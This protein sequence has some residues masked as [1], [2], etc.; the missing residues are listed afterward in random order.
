VGSNVVFGAGEYGPS[1]HA[2]QR[3]LG[4][5]L[6][7]VVQ[8][9]SVPTQLR[10]DIKN[11]AAGNAVAFEFRVGI[12]LRQSFVELA[13]KLALA[14]PI[15]DGDLEDLRT[16][17]LKFHGTVDD[18]ERMFMAGLL[19]SANV[20]SLRRMA[21][22]PGASITFTF[23]TITNARV[24]HII[25]LG[26]ETVPESVAKPAREGADAL[27]HLKVG[28]ALEK[29]AESESAAGKA[30]LANAGEFKAQA[31][32]LV[33][34][35]RSH[36]VSLGQM[37]QAILAAAS[38][39]SAG[40]KV[41]AGTAFAI[42]DDAGSS[43]AGDLLSGR[44]KVDALI[45]AA[46]GRLSIPAG[47]VAF[48]VTAAQKSGMKGDTIYLQ[49]SLNIADLKDRS[50]VIHELRHAEEDKAASPTAAPSFP[51]KNQMELRAYRAQAH[52]ILGQMLRQA[53]PDQARSASEAAKGG[54]LVLGALVLE[55][56]TDVARFQPALELVFGAAPAPFTQTPA[57]VRNTLAVPAARI[58]AAVLQ[59]IDTAYGL[60]RGEKGV[61]E[62]LAGESLIHWIFRI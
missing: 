56:Q 30:I 62:G 34:F 21:I 31:T 26:R 2:G 16:Q 11:D 42:A 8:Q 27:K 5:E 20:A 51:V 4:H 39:S 53:A 14:G 12:E 17:A 22:A 52:Y 43:V 6:A 13:Q 40:D 3:L 33:N 45:P 25:D 18:R 50:D 48:Y 37:L 54:G 49:T 38:D 19:D 23:A 1:T 47:T 58:E 10:R 61:V 32:A 41:L 24:Q 28:D 55:G 29:A 44:I 60:T 36:G 59:D 9:G 35:A 46:F 7:H 15:M 57:Q